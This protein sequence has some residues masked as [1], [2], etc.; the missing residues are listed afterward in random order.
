MSRGVFS[1]ANYLLRASGL[2][3]ATPLTLACWVRPTAGTPE[4]DLVGIYYTAGATAALDGW[5]IGL[6]TSTAIASARAGDNIGT[7]QSTG[8]NANQNAWNHLGGVFTS[9]TSRLV[10][11]NGVAGTSNS[12]SRIPSNTVTKSAI[13]LR[14]LN[15][16][17]VSNPATVCNIAEVA[18][19]NVALTAAE[20][21]I[22]S[23][24]FSPLFVHSQNLIAYYPCIAGDGS[25][26]ENNAF[27]SVQ[28]MAQQ[29]TVSVQQH[30]RMLYRSP[31]VT[32]AVPDVVNVNPRAVIE[33]LQAINRSSAF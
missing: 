32:I 4:Q 7:S 5:L 19:W 23:L 2:I 11:L 28:Q 14:I 21:T 1:T 12:G 15:N 8:G 6:N 29:G 27:R 16:N 22:L 17:T 26:N 3:T 33:R 24:G 30:T 31:R 9:T 18:F 13:G 10:Y 20:M 25:G